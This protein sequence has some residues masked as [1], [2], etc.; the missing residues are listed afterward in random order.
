MPHVVVVG[1]GFAGLSATQQLA[2]EGFEVTLLDRHPYNTF[3]PLLYQVATGGLNA[4]DVTYSLRYFSARYENV[5][6][7][8][9]T[10]FGIDHEAR[11]VRCDPGPD[12]SYDYVV[13]ANGIT[14]NHFGIPGAAEYSMSMY[15]RSEALRVRDTI[16]GGIETIAGMSTPH[17]GGFTVVVVGGGATGVEMAGQL[18][19]L[20]QVAVPQVYPELNPALV[21]VV[22]VEMGP[23]LLAPF[24]PKLRKYTLRELVKRGVDV[25]LN[26]AISEVH[27]D[28]VD[29]KD[30][31]T[32]PV[33]L[34]IWAAGVAGDPLVR[35]WG[36]PIGR[37]GRIEVKTDLR[38]TNDDR[39]FA[40]GDNCIVVDAPLPQLAQP[41]LQM[42][43]HVGQQITRIHRGVPTAPFSYHD[44]GTMAT[45][46]RADAVVQLPNGLKLT[47]LPAWLG[48]ITLH[49]MFLLGSRNR[50]QTLI[51]L[52]VR[53]T[54]LGRSGVIIGDVME[55]PKMRS[56]KGVGEEPIKSEEADVLQSGD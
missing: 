15:T 35:D 11:K 5:H 25:R 31:T 40:I 2:K 54:G 45:I 52:A 44:K 55:P 23:E 28:K 29:F 18:A 1:A 48:W 16:F 14:T 49:V 33:D 13:I 6:F 10:V 17:S 41:A 37:G 56:L 21:Q 38:T 51:N 36:L 34:V 22:L 47:G 32:M 43:K 19:E 3:Q 20:K 9:C 39:V 4:G 42:G 8:R 46:G 53:Y 50:V 24:D 7:R 30:G 27:A 12:M 26:T